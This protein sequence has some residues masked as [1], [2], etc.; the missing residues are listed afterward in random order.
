VWLLDLATEK[1]TGSMGVEAC[2]D[3]AFS[4]DGQQL[5]VDTLN[6]LAIFDA[7]T[8]RRIYD[9]PAHDSTIFALD[10]SPDGEWIASGSADRTVRIWT[11]DGHRVAILAGHRRKVNGVA[12]T[13]DGQSLVSSDNGTGLRVTHVE[14]LRELLTIETP[15]SGLKLMRSLG[16]GQ[17][18]AMLDKT[19]SLV[20]VGPSSAT[21]AP[22]TGR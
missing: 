18:I 14:T 1:I 2:H 12:F 5:A 22:E 17:R 21:P 11:P 6:R 15:V 20:I 8:G 9:F 19:Y 4:P 3:V 16:N 13:A 10:W 7:A